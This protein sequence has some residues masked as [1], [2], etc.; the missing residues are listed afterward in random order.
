L[1][2]AQPVFHIDPPARI[3]EEEAAQ[4][5]LVQEAGVMERN[6]GAANAKGG[7]CRRNAGP[8]NAGHTGCCVRIGN[9]SQA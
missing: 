7:W 1:R 6:I 2:Q 4:F 9:L 8:R 3:S 5:V